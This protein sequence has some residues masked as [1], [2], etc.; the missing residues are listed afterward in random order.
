MAEPFI[1]EIRMFAGSFAPRGWAMCDGQVLAIAQNN[2]LFA[3][4]GTT[5][6]GDG[7]TVFALP[8]QRGRIPIHAGT[9]PGLSSRSFGERGGTETVALSSGELPAHDHPAMGL[10][11]GGG[12]TGPSGAAP[13]ITADNTYGRPIDEPPNLVDMNPGAIAPT[14]GD[15]AHNNVQPFLCV[16]F[17]VALIGIFPSRN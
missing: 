15:Q 11:D 1:G 4:L 16:N 13:A 5:F 9:G 3:L 8:D 2:A 17:I 12:L 10:D 14:G 6:G 7:R